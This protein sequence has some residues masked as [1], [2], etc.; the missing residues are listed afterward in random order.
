MPATLTVSAQPA[1]R[2]YEAANPAFTASFAGFIPPDT[3][4][5]VVTGSPAFTVAANGYPDSPV[6]TVITVSTGQGTLALISPNYV[7]SLATSTLTVSCKEAQF[8]E[9]G[10]N[11]SVAIPIPVG[12]PFYLTASASSGLPVTYTVESGPGNVGPGIFGG[13]ALTATGAGTITV[14]IS[15][16]GNNNFNA[17]TPVNIMFTGH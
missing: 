2:C 8:I 14:Q 9:P 6:G 11:P 1:T 5:S 4:S 10:L 17:A 3:Q 7:L 16:P 15:Q 12:V 13:T